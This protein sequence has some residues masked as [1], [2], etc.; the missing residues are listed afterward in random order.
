MVAE[1]S[2][3]PVRFRLVINANAERLAHTVRM[4]ILKMNKR[5]AMWLRN[6][7]T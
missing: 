5:A 6:G 2:D 3:H 4:G 7:N 1:T